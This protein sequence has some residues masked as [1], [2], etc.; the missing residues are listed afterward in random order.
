MAI[1][2]RIPASAAMIYGACRGASPLCI[3]SL[4]PKIGGSG[5]VKANRLSQANS[6]VIPF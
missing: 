2:L 4:P 1:L 5:G 3:S 6:V